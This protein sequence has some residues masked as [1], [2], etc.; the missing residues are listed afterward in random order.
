MFSPPPPLFQEPHYTITETQYHD[1]LD[2]AQRPGSNC[3][4][5]LYPIGESRW[6]DSSGKPPQERNFLN[7]LNSGTPEFEHL[8]GD[9]VKDNFNFEE[10]LDE[11]LNSETATQNKKRGNYQKCYG[12]AGGLNVQRRTDEDVM[13]HYGAAMPVALTGTK[14]ELGLMQAMTLVG[15]AVGVFTSNKEN[16]PEK[17]ALQMEYI[18]DLI[19][20]EVDFGLVTQA[21]LPMTD[22]SSV[23]RHVDSQNGTDL[24]GQVLTVSKIVKDRKNGT[25]HRETLIANQK[26]SLEEAI[27]RKMVSKQLSERLVSYLMG[28]DFFRHPNTSVEDF[29]NYGAGS[30]GIFVSKDRESGAFTNVGL[31]SKPA[32]NKSLFFV[33]G[34]SSAVLSFQEQMLPS[35]DFTLHD[36]VSLCAATVFCV[37]YETMIHSMISGSLAEVWPNRH[38]YNGGVVGAMIDLANK[39]NGGAHRGGGK[40][41][42]CQPGYK[43]L[44][45]ENIQ[46]H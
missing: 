36:A 34:Y 2:N 1:S 41:R 44:E 22:G 33:S 31:S 45:I 14:N 19:D 7:V 43:L 6:D 3:S 29:C 16:I 15:K 24:C 40:T 35:G 42:R 46:T 13:K 26:K 9:I 38:G 21:F 30:E 23:K 27:A 10:R 20:Q 5:E 28:I 18:H 17:V 8:I 12:V 4:I 39:R 25:L 32:M 37:S 11:F